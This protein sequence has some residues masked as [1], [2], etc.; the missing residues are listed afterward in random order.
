[1]PQRLEPD[2]TFGEISAGE[3]K[4][5]IGEAIRLDP[6]NL[7]QCQPQRCGF[8]L[9][10]FLVFGERDLAGHKLPEPATHNRSNS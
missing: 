6:T 7:R 8:T 5:F 9:E 2:A 4:D 3:F 10:H 1:M